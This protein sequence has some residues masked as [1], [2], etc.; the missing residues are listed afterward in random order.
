V[1]IP[2][3]VGLLSDGLRAEVVVEVVGRL[4]AEPFP[5]ERRVDFPGVGVRETWIAR[6][7]IVVIESAD[8]VSPIFAA[9]KIVLVAAVEIPLEARPRVGAEI[10]EPADVRSP[11]AEIKA[12]RM[13][14]V[15][16]AL[17]GG[18]AG[19]LRDAP[20]NVLAEDACVRGE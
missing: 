20:K 8:V 6:A 17:H 14:P 10:F 9:G 18:L 2:G 4:G 5:I 13:R 1:E 12:A 19:G 16:A 11:R 3:A 15:E 7:G